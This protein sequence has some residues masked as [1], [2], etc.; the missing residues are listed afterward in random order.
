MVFDE[1]VLVVMLLVVIS[2]VGKVDEDVDP[3]NCV[4]EELIIVVVLVIVLVLVDVV[5][6]GQ[7]Q[8]WN[9]SPPFSTLFFKF[10]SPSF[11]ISLHRPLTSLG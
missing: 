10:S 1:D 2:I 9:L 6:G 3:G 4:D 8:R 7:V 11:S 5:G